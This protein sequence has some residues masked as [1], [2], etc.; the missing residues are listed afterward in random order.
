MNSR[1]KAQLDSLH[2]TFLGLT[3]A[4]IEVVKKI[5][6]LCKPTWSRGR[7]AHRLGSTKALSRH[8]KK[9]HKERARTRTLAVPLTMVRLVCCNTLRGRKAS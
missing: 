1:N 5:H 9:L 4:R 3:V 7:Q 8:L 6:R 2:K